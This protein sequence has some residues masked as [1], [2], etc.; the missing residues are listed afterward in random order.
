MYNKNVLLLY[1]QTFFFYLIVRNDYKRT[2]LLK[3]GKFTSRNIS[4]C[5]TL[6]CSYAR[7][8]D[9]KILDTTKRWDI[10]LG[11]FTSRNLSQR[12]TLFNSYAGRLDLTIFDNTNVFFDQPTGY[13][14]Y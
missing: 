11:K 12:V 3:F 1:C 13:K 14:F 10:K 5:V 2:Y 4:R 8:L 6:F 7:K 9:V